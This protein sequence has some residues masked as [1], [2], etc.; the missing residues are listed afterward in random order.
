MKK[1]NKSLRGYNVDEVNNFVDEV[2]VKVE[3]MVKQL[4]ESEQ[5]RKKQ[6]E[7]LAVL[8]Q[9]LKHFEN[10]ENTLNRAVLA[11]EEAGESIKNSARQ[12]RSMLLEDAKRNASRIVNE[13][14]LRAEKTEYEASVLQK[15]INVFKRRIRSIIE[16]QL[17][18]IDEFDQVEL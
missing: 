15:N 18:V 17:D 4:S 11:A 12:E 13:A 16:S 8:R 10:I 5:E 14:L 7:E 1:F 6:E 3:D 2:I 9:K